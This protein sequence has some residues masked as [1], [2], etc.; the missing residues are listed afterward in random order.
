MGF[1]PLLICPCWGEVLSKHGA[2]F[3]V[4]Y[5]CGSAGRSWNGQAAL[6]DAELLPLKQTANYSVMACS[7][8]SRLL[9][10]FVVDI[11]SFDK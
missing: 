6:G 11:T 1:E 10:F 3:T 7:T 4:L 8:L 5:T 2:F 9:V